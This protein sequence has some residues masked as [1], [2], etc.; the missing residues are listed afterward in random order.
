MNAATLAMSVG[1]VAVFVN[2]SIRADLGALADEVETDARNATC[3]FFTGIGI[4]FFILFGL[5]VLLQAFVVE[6]NMTNTR[7]ILQ[8]FQHVV[9]LFAAVPIFSAIAAQRTYK[10][11]AEIV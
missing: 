4:I 8:G 2:Q 6:K 1:L 3:T 11:R 10:L 9:F 5:I 7:S